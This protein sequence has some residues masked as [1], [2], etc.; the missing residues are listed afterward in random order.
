M[1]HTCAAPLVCLPA[2]LP[3]WRT[4][5]QTAVSQG[6]DHLKHLPRHGGAQQRGLHLLFISVCHRGSKAGGDRQASGSEGQ[7]GAGRMCMRQPPTATGRHRYSPSKQSAGH[8]PHASLPWRPSGRARWR[9]ASPPARGC[10]ATRATQTGGGPRPRC[11]GNRRRRRGRASDA[12]FAREK[13]RSRGGTGLEAAIPY[14]KCAPEHL[15]A[16]EEAAHAAHVATHVEA[17]A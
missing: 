11:R 14:Q 15:I 9:R 17:R 1:A 5:R 3:A 12:C 7:Q 13:S 6:V 2:C 16:H 10:R 8:A 4:W